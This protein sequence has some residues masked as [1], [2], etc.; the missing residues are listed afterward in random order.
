MWNIKL[1]LNKTTAES[2]HICCWGKDVLI[3]MGADLLLFF[4]KKIWQPC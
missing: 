4:P 2:L 1:Y 3:I